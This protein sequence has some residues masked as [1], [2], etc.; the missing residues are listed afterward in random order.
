MVYGLDFT[1]SF[2]RRPVLEEI[3]GKFFTKGIS[4]YLCRAGQGKKEEG[5]KAILDWLEGRLNF[6]IKK[7]KRGQQFYRQV[8]FKKGQLAKMGKVVIL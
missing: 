4:Y 5:I 8:Y 3:H 2:Y 1:G 6:F 7:F